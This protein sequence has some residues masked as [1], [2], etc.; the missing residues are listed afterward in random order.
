M[1]KLSYIFPALM[2][3]MLP[4][5]LFAQDLVLQD[6]VGSGNQYLNT[7]IFQDTS[8]AAFQGGTRVYVLKKDGVYLLNA[9]LA[10][11]NKTLSF[12][13]E[14]GSSGHYDPTV[15]L[16]PGT[17]GNP[18]GEFANLAGG[19]IYL[20]HIIITG[21][22]EPVD[23]NLDHL[24]GGLI[25]LN[26]SGSGGSIYVDSCILKSVNG[27]LLRTD[28]QPHVVKVTNSIFADMGFE[29][30]SNFGA[31]KGIDLRN[32]IVDTC[33]IEN[34]TFVNLQDRVVRH[35][36]STLG[37]IKNFIFNHNTIVNSVSYHGFLSLGRVDSTGAGILQITNNLLVD[38]F[39]LGAD[40]AYI[41]QVEFSDPGELD[42]VNLQPRMA[43]VL[44]N[45]NLAA[46]WNI[47]N[48]YYAVSDSGQA[49]LN[50]PLPNGPYYQSEGP[51]LTWGMNTTLAAQ[52]KDTTK[53]FKQV[54]ITLNNTPP[55]MTKM[56]RWIY[57]PR[58]LGG[59]G[60]QKNGNDPNFTKDSPGHW[61]YDYNRRHVEYYFDTLNCNIAGTASLLASM[62]TTDGIVAGDPRWGT[63]TLTTTP[64][65][66]SG[67]EIKFGTVNLLS[68]KKD[69]IQLTNVGPGTVH[70]TV[71]SSN[72]A[73]AAASGSV[74]VNSGANAYL[75]ITFTPADTSSQSG[76]IKLVYDALGSPDSVAVSG[77]GNKVTGVA[78]A[79]SLLPKEFSLAQNYPNPFNPST[80]IAYAVPK[81]SQ[82]TL[83]IFDVLGRRVAT[84]VNGVMQPGFYTANFNASSMSSGIYFY[85]LSSPGVIFIKKMML[86]K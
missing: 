16:Y 52:G 53:G 61:T 54:A 56:I 66:V 51:W 68:S 28:G 13:C 23:S 60:K 46:K 9:Q 41:R 14:Y 40:T 22:Y 73:F 10:F 27:N 17:N 69:S 32:N 71:T 50:L 29:G 39:A 37:P 11:A 55:L 2:V 82:I 15:Y 4:M 59:D 34:C 19:A 7:L 8:S 20:K 70:F 72:S 43:W 80:Q 74:A 38:H 3:L 6:Y 67:H 62:T 18:P 31:G 47:S 85:R 86:L 21:Y 76:Y 57:E 5:A 30:T 65:T 75:V 48:N 83:E 45:R 44:T 63:P 79:Q 58:S 84:L 42:T 78:D 64:V 12:R 77:K 33:D 35:Y 24:Q 1:L 25:D 81:A 26:A 36:Q 49:M